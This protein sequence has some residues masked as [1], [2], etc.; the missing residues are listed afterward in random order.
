MKTNLSFAPMLTAAVLTLSAAAAYGQAP[1]N[2]SV[3][4]AFETTNASLTAGKY[5]VMPM[6]NRSLSV[7]R[8]ENLGTGN[9]TMVIAAASID[10][11]PGGARLVFKCGSVR[12][13]AL[14]EAYDDYGRG[15]KFST[16]RLTS[17]EIERVAVVYLHRT[18]AE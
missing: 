15:W 18:D 3:P 5:A 4:F 12:G 13:C 8:I 2:A 11:A 17:A 1:L 16:P 9:S 6:T 14:A 10:K 7:V